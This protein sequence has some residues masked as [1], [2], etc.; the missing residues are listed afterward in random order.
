MQLSKELAF[1]A[2]QTSALRFYLA[3]KHLRSAGQNSFLSPSGFC[4]FQAIENM[5]KAIG[6]F[7]DANFHP[8][9][10]GHDVLK[11]IGHL[12]T[13]GVKMR[14]I[15]IPAHWFRW[16]EFTRYP[17]QGV[18]F[19]SADVHYLDEIF[20]DLVCMILSQHKN[21]LLLHIVFDGRH[22][23]ERQI[24]IRDNRHFKRLEAHLTSVLQRPG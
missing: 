19:G 7:H 4:A 6:F 18:G 24:L 1:D 8:E 22:A 10:F 16:Q 20:T 14:G 13:L 11:L 12:E 3:A 21:S 9:K 23:E 2:W 15:K 5:L 17:E